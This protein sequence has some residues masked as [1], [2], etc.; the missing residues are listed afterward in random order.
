MNTMHKLIPF[1]IIGVGKGFIASAFSKGNNPMYCQ[2][3]NILL[4]GK[5]NILRTGA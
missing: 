3:D 4:I 5:M 2:L 1:E